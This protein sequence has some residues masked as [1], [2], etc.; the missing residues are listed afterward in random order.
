MKRENNSEREREEGE[1]RDFTRGPSS[2][3]YARGSLACT[4]A[5]IALSIFTSSHPDAA[6]AVT[7]LTPVADAVLPVS[8]PGARPLLRAEGFPGDLIERFSLCCD[9]SDFGRGRTT[10]RGRE[11]GEGWDFTRGPSSG[12][13][14]CTHAR[15]RTH[16]NYQ[17]TA[18]YR[19]LLAAERRIWRIGQNSRV[20]P[21]PSGSGR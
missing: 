4:H 1:G 16:G 14:A 20:R 13:L 7:V 10:G 15:T 5:R 6:A 2:G 8:L 3:S 9:E 18:T 11:E 17:S 19:P 12:S 21:R